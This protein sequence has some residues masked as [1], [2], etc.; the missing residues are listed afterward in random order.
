MH[1]PASD[2]RVQGTPGCGL[3]AYVA[4]LGTFATAGIVGMVLA[5]G[6]LIQAGASAGPMRYIPGPMVAVWQMEALRE[7]GLVGLTEAPLAFHDE[8]PLRDATTACAL[9]EDRLVRVAE[10]EALTLPYGQIAGVELE[11]NPYGD[12]SVIARGEAGAPT[13]TCRFGPE[14]GAERMHRQL[15]SEKAEARG[16]AAPGPERP[17]GAVP[18]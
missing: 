14:E 7:A 2:P 9:M 1:N 5:T 6:Q 8:S 13:V 4:L 15:L 17:V 11:G 10:G 18:L 16:E 3:A 12:A